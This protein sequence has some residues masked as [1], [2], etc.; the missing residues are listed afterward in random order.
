M[1]H[2]IGAGVVAVGRNRR[3]LHGRLPTP[4]TVSNYLSATCLLLSLLFN[5]IVIYRSRSARDRRHKTF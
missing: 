1:A 5:S 4:Q 2:D 3:P